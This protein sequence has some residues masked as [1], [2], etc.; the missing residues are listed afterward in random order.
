MGEPIELERTRATEEL[1]RSRAELAS[2]LR[3]LEGRVRDALSP[4]RALNAHLGWFLAGAF[5]L[6]VGLAVSRRE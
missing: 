5:A 6:G 2:S 3:S 1:E 4:S